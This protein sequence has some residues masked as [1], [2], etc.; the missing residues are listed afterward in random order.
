MSEGEFKR[1]AVNVK[2]LAKRA[3]SSQR[4]KMLKLEELLATR[5]QLEK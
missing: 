2:A 5:D 1:G 4:A 3:G